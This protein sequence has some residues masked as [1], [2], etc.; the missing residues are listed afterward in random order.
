MGLLCHSER[1][2]NQVNLQYVVVEKVIVTSKNSTLRE[3][4]GTM[5]V[6]HVMS[7]APS[8]LRVTRRRKKNMNE[9]HIDTRMLSEEIVS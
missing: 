9:Q 8:N 2:A 3:K 5:T 1:K 6:Y 4:R 7:R